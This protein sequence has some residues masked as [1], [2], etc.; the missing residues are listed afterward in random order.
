MFAGQLC[1]CDLLEIDR[2]DPTRYAIGRLRIDWRSVVYV[3]AVK[4]VGH[5]IAMG[6][7]Y[8]LGAC[9][10]QTLY[11]GCGARSRRMGLESQRVVR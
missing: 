11:R 5:L 4:A 1:A 2:A 9:R 8:D 6:L 7:P 3:L 10:E